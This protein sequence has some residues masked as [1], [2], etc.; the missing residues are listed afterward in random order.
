MHDTPSSLSLSL[1]RA[2]PLLVFNVF[3]R[4]VLIPND[5][6]IP[7][8]AHN[9]HHTCTHAHDTVLQQLA[10]VFVFEL[11]VHGVATILALV[12]HWLKGAVHGGRVQ[13]PLA[14]RG[15]DDTV[16]VVRARVAI[17]VSQTPPQITEPHSHNLP[18]SRLNAQCVI[19]SNSYQHLVTLR[20]VYLQLHYCCMF[21]NTLHN[22]DNH[23]QIQLHRFPL[24]VKPN[25]PYHCILTEM[26]NIY[27]HQSADMDQLAHLAL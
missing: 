15:R 22:C 26:A 9:A 14:I 18:Q 10:L 3:L 24:S 5:G 27:S 12:A 16:R 25:T 8:A 6:T 17:L 19:W 20:T 7:T 4:Y 21:V 1:L 2:R 11:V 23:V 13:C